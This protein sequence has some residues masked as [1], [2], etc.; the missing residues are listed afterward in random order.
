MSQFKFEM[1]GTEYTI[2]HVGGFLNQ[3]FVYLHKHFLHNQPFDRLQFE[4]AAHT[5]FDSHLR[6]WAAHDA[7]FNNFTI[8]WLRRLEQGHFAA[9][10]DIWEFAL[11]LASNWENNHPSNR[12]H[13]GT[14][15]YFWGMTVV[16]RGDLDRAFLL[17][18]QALHEDIESSGTAFPDTPASAFAI[19]N[20][21][22]QAKH[23][24]TRCK[25]LLPF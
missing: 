5:Y 21:Q 17:M 13:K 14:P 20:H 19:L 11:T 1:G 22:K 16:L 2:Q 7:F 15:Y 12:L 23:F 3:E 18:H 6:D 24:A 25:R 10:E 9:A 8:I 4:K